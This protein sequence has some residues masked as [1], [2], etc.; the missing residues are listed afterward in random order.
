M[1]T[2]PK[3]KPLVNAL[4]ASD[5][6]LAVEPTEAKRLFAMAAPDLSEFSEIKAGPVAEVAR[7]GVP[8]SQVGTTAVIPVM[9]MLNKRFGFGSFASSY[10]AISTAVQA[11]VADSE[12][13]T[14]LLRIDSPGGF[15]PGVADAA[16]VI[17]AASEQ[18][19]VIAQVDGL[20]ASGAIWLGSQATTVIAGRQD[21]VGSIGVF[22]A[23]YDFS[24]MLE[25]EGVKVE[26]FTTGAHKA[27]GL[28]GTALSD[29]Q[30]KEMQARVDEMGDAFVA[31]LARGRGMSEKDVRSVADGRIFNS[32]VAAKNGLIDSIGTF[33]QTMHALQEA[34]NRK[35]RTRRARI[36]VAMSQNAK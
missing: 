11:A 1:T 31:D 15:V 34:D 23:F 4:P 28:P 6:L 17:H 27:A 8:V 30:R 21:R 25:K 22:S 18:K 5:T 33:S 3:Y 14:I 9:G 7:L 32:D 10:L 36:E 24:E 2:Q 26:V 19:T 13:K 35:G 12:V 16:D 20:M 29:E